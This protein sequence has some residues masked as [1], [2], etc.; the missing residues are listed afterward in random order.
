MKKTIT[1][2]IAILLVGTINA[3]F[4]ITNADFES[5][6]AMSS[7]GTNHY[8]DG[9][10]IAENK[11]GIFVASE[12]GL[13]PGEGRNGSQ[14]LK[15]VIRDSNGT[16]GDVMLFSSNVDVST[17][18]P[19]EYTFS[20]WT[21]VETE[22]GNKALWLVVGARDADGKAVN[23]LLTRVDNGGTMTDVANW[24]NGYVEATATVTFT[25]P[26]VKTLDFRIMHATVNNTY[27]FDDISL[28]T[29]ASLSTKSFETIGVKMYPNPS[30][31][32]DFTTIKS[33]SGLENITLYSLTGKQILNE[34]INTNEFRFDTSK[35]AKGIYLVEVA[36]SKGKSTSKLVIQ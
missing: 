6:T 21:K 12:S 1:F 32:S 28:S 25:D 18:Q 17:Y 13:A 4:S 9:Y 11:T 3:Q 34:K 36:N 14:A 2:I 27:Y 7:D 20:I 19:G 8:I 35:Y 5:N 31:A 16:G 26:S 29:T 30:S 22:V 15:S 10:R 33:T 23:G 24:H